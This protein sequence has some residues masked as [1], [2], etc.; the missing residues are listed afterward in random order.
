MKEVIT[1]QFKICSKC[2]KELPLYK[3]SFRTD[4]GKY[5]GALCNLCNTGLG[6]FKDNPELL[7]LAAE[8]LKNK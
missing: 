1:D 6:H 3:F 5:R 8:Y 2:G 4:T 7:I